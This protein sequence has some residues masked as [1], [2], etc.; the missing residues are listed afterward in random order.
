MSDYLEFVDERL[1][2]ASEH[3]AAGR[4]QAAREAFLAAR[5]E[6]PNSHPFRARL[7]RWAGECAHSER[8]TKIIAAV[9]R[10]DIR[11]A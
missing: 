1:A 10:S 2:A 9:E 4:W 5:A 8:A 7:A 6:L 11:L 3:R